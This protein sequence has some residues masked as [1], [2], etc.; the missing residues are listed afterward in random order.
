MRK[1][2]KVTII[3][4]V[5][6]V[7]AAT[8]LVAP[9]AVKAISTASKV[10]DIV[11][12]YHTEYADEVH[13]I[14]NNNISE[15]T[16]RALSGKWTVALFGLDSRSQK[17]LSRANSDVIMIASIDSDTGEIKIASVFRDTCL[18]LN[19]KFRKANYAYAQGG[20]ELAVKMLDENFDLQINDYASMSWA[21]VADAIN[22]LG[23]VDIDVTDQQMK[24]ING[25]ITETVNSTGIPSVQ[26]EQS[27][28]Q[29]LDGV[30]TVAYC[31]IRYDAEDY[32]RAEKQR[33]VLKQVLEKAGTS[34][35]DTVERA[36]KAALPYTRTSIGIPK[37]LTV[38]KD[39]RKYTLQGYCGLPDKR[40]EKTVSGN[41]FVF[42][43][44]LSLSVTTLHDYLYDS[45]DYVPS[46]GAREISD[47]IDA[48]RG[49]K[50]VQETDGTEETL[51]EETQA[52]EE[53]TGDETKDAV[54]D[55]GKEETKAR[56]KGPGEVM[57]TGTATGANADP[58][59]K[60]GA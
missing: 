13:K 4:V 37:V 57:E 26:L 11:K 28:M 16:K 33:E 53:T 14:E 5:A 25:Y 50:I 49:G 6:A 45:T 51:R 24:W 34:D 31:R 10:A 15:D 21:G 39:M 35:G 18:E 36:V 7:A 58:V 9:K 40:I 23:G 41:D 19:G 47:R 59:P 60:P 54:K 20:P 12:E 38:L 22:E 3:T 30:Q 1:M 27:G 55:A 52:A 56:P 46:N 48:Y 42:A 43:N 17:E 32:G 2:K 44:P 29:H 8:A